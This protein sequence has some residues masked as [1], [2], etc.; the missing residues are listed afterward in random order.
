MRRY[1]LITTKKF[2]AGL[3]NLLPSWKRHTLITE[4]LIWPTAF[5][6]KQL[7][8]EYLSEHIF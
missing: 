1:Y 6:L 2:R 5:G 3:Y 7:D 8:P 4:L